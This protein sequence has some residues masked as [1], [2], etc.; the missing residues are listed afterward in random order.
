MINFTFTRNPSVK[1]GV[2]IETAGLVQAD[3]TLVLIGRMAASGSTAVENAPVYITNFGDPVAAATEC[4]SLFGAASEL[5]SMVVAAIKAVQLSDNPSP[6]YPKLRVIPMASTKVDTDLAAALAANQSV[7]MPFVVTPFASSDATARTA[8]RAHLNLISGQ[9]RGDNGQFGSFGVMA[10]VGTPSSVITDGLAAASEKIMIASLPD[11]GGANTVPQ[12]AAAFAAMCAAC[13][14]PFLPLNGLSI[15]GLVQPASRADWHVAGDT[16][17]AS[18]VLDAGVTPLVCGD[19][20]AIRLPRSVTTYRPTSSIEANSYFDM[21][22]WQVLYYYRQNAY[23]LAQQ[24]RYKRAKATDKKLL[25]LK[26]ELVVLAKTFEALEMF[27]YVDS[28]ASQFTVTRQASNRSAAVYILP[29][30]VVP[31]FHNKGIGIE[32]TTQFDSF[33]L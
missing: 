6:A 19:D 13:G 7:P 25:A 1:T 21:Q 30:N 24:T 23:A 8:L 22:D 33:T 29:V 11:T 12:V 32:G 27:Q 15:G 18:L 31:G 10:S 20:G 3:N 16:G 5:G 26:S 2:D 28:L 14:V 9:D 4:T 17:S